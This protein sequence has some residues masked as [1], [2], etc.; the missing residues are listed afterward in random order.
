MSQSLSKE[1]SNSKKGGI[2]YWPGAKALEGSVSA[3]KDASLGEPEVQVVTV[4]AMAEYMK[5]QE[6]K[7]KALA[8]G[9]AK[10]SAPLTQPG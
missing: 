3:S 6:E 2:N 8:Q 7:K 9:G 5:K 4:D 1:D 10:S